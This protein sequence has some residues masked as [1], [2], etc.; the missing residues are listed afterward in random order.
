MSVVSGDEVSSSEVVNRF[1]KYVRDP[2]YSEAKYWKGNLSPKYGSNETMDDTKLAGRSIDYPG[3][4]DIREIKSSIW[5]TTYYPDTIA[6]AMV[7]ALKEFANK[8]T[9]VRRARYGYKSTSWHRKNTTKKY[10]VH[11]GG[12]GIVRLSNA[13]AFSS[14]YTNSALFKGYLLHSYYVRQY[15]D[16][17]R[18][19]SYTNRNNAST[20]DIRTCHS[21]CHNSCHG[22]RGRR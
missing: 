14:S 3:P 11:K 8:T 16:T 9:V 17:L 18:S 1:K 22:S 4:Y 12:Y 21:S 19:S 2:A 10:A 15:I 13:Y 7:S 20:V 5:Y 6:K